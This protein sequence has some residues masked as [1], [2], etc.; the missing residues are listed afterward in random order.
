[1][2]NIILIHQ[3]KCTNIACKCKFMQIFPYGKKYSKNYINNFL[4]GINMLLESIFVELDYQKNDKLTLLLAEHY[5]NFKDNPILSYSMIQTILYF[6]TKVLN[7]NQLFILLTAFTKYIAKCNDKYK[8]IQENKNIE[9]ET[10]INKQQIMFKKIF[11]NHKYLVKIKNIIKKYAS[12]CIQLI[13]Y[14]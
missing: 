7:I 14:I 5:C 8:I 1:M 9:E 2:I 11:E 3:E 6:Y 4:E 12:N 13:F 10:F